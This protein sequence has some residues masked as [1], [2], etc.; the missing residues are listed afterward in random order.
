MSEVL[1]AGRRATSLAKEEVRRKKDSGK[2][3]ERRIK[4]G[5]SEGEGKKS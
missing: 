2:E 1:L 4:K 5:K 3:R